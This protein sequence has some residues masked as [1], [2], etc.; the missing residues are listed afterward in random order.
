[1]NTSKPYKQRIL[2]LLEKVGIEGADNAKICKDTGIPS[3][4]QVYLLTQEL[5]RRGKITARREGRK[6]VF[7][8]LD[9]PSTNSFRGYWRVISSP[10]FD[11]ETLEMETI[12]FVR[13]EGEKFAF[14]GTFHIGLIL[15]EFD[16]RLDGKRVLFSFKASGELEPMHGAGTISLLDKQMEFRLMFFHGD[17]FTFMC[18]RS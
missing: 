7:F 6:W 8:P 5:T 2:D 9:T 4:Q 1:M 17:K 15:G 11:R 16:G 18:E 13:V 14:G 3:Y 12:P 10:E